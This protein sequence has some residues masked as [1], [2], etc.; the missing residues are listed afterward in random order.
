MDT[1]MFNVFTDSQSA[2]RTIESE[3]I[4][5]RTA[6]WDILDSICYIDDVVILLRGGIV[7]TDL[8]GMRKRFDY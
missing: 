5:L 6:I 7:N 4:T 3:T 2:I 1:G 8:D